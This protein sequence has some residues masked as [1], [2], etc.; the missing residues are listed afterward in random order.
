MTI[1]TKCAVCGKEAEVTVA[2]SAAVPVSYAY[3]TE[4]LNSGIEPYSAL[5]AS[6][7]CVGHF[8]EDFN[9]DYAEY[10]RCQLQMHGISIE[11]FNED[12]SEL[13]KQIW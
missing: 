5:V 8:P 13:S 1:K 4:C 9:L 10:Y 6:A 2:T 7:A 11:K 3:C 12:I